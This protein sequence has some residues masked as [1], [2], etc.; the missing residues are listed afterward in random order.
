M[1]TW[2]RGR[3]AIDLI[4]DDALDLLVL[5][6]RLLELDPALLAARLVAR[7]DRFAE[8]VLDALEVDLDF[9]A[10]LRRGI[11]AVIG[12]FL[13]RHAALGLQADVDERH[14]FFDRDDPALDDGA[15]EGLILA[16][17]LVQ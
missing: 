4:E 7:N 15:F 13:Q 14:V 12:E 11:A 3:N 1:S 8:R 2:L 5:L 16:V 9:V 17:G 10:D 6:E